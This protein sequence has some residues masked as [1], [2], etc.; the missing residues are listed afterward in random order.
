MTEEAPAIFVALELSAF[1]AYIRQSV[2]L[3]PLANVGHIVSLVLFAGAIA[4]MDVRLLGGFSATSPARVLVRARRY[5]IG[6]FLLMV[7]TG[8]ILFT[9]EASHLATNHV[10]QLKVVIIGAALVNVAIFEFGLRPSVVNL[11]PGVA[12]PQRARVA[13][14]LSLGLWIAVAACGRSI[15]YF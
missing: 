10:F 12:M 4:V 11:P 9:A 13:A 8:F 15:A 5:A 3:F 7:A 14:M 6:A 1:G 2:W